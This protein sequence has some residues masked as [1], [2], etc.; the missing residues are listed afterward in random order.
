MDD[1]IVE[2]AVELLRAFP[3]A[4]LP[5]PDDEG[6]WEQWVERAEQEAR[7]LGVDLTTQEDFPLITRAESRPQHGP[8]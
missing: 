6:A 1:P 7:L 4:W 8:C 3:E 2:L 5:D